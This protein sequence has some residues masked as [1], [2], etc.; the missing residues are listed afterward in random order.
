VDGGE[1]FD[2]CL[3]HHLIREVPGG[4]QEDQH[5]DA[6]GVCPEDGDPWYEY[7]FRGEAGPGM[8]SISDMTNRIEELEA[9][10][11]KAVEALDDLLEALTAKDRFGDSSL[12][13]TGPMANLKWLIEA[14]GTARAALTTK[15]QT[16]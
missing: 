8:Y 7:T 12:T 6:D 5:M 9:K 13:I 3:K 11:A 4:F 14:E 10:L 2:L 1:L 15:E 16:K